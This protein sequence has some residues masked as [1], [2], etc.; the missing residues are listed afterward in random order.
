MPKSRVARS[1]FFF[2]TGEARLV[3]WDVSAW[4]VA[5]GG[6][7]KSTMTTPPLGQVRQPPKK[8]KESSGELSTSVG[9]AVLLSPEMFLRD[10]CQVSRHRSLIH[11]ERTTS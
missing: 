3:R 10:S 6:R 4:V 9:Q 8:Q 1:S 2:A 5:K 7:D 11:S